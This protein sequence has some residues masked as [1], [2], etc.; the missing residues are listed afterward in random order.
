MT[1]DLA[2]RPLTGRVAIVTGASG[3][4]VGSA[5]A[6]LLG[7]RGAHVVV[8]YLRNRAGADGV[9]ADIIS[10]GCRAIAVQADI[11]DPADVTRLVDQ[12][13]GTFGR[14]DVLVSNTPAARY[15]VNSRADADGPLG[16]GPFENFTWE[17]FAPWFTAR[18]LAAF[19]TTQAVLPAMRAQRGGRLIYVGSDHADGPAA[20]G[21]IAN[22]TGSAALV[23]FV[24]YLAHELGGYGITA[25]VVSPGGID[26]PSSRARFL[27]TPES[28]GASV[29]LGRLA[30]PEDVA[31]VI[32]F[33]AGDDSAFMTGTV[34]HV[35]GGFGI[36]RAPTL[37]IAR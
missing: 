2:I 7:A 14:I 8:N 27:M 37:K 1:A 25:N 33:F 19:L 29:P 26:S 28:I 32:A 31:G 17:S 9:V 21:M 35:N 34:A 36:G 18:V 30:K 24:R 4:G 5:T 6:R 22:G 13:L 12:A 15:A 20:P 3:G 16:P 23:T 10:R 11:S